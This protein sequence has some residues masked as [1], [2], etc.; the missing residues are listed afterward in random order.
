[1]ERFALGLLSHA[2]GIIN[3]ARYPIHTG[4]LEGIHNKTKVI[5]RQAYG[6]RDNHYFILKVKA[7]FPGRLQPD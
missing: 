4:V 2:D 5:K 1:L 7:A 6:F 3:H